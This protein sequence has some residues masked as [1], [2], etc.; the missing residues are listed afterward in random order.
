MIRLMTN[1]TYLFI[2]LGYALLMFSVGAVTSFMPKYLEEIF[3]IPASKVNVIFGEFL[4]L[5]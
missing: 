4:L 1:T 3:R 2:I 5:V